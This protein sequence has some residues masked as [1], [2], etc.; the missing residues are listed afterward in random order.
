M[1]F[2]SVSG[3]NRTALSARGVFMKILAEYGVVRRGQDVFQAD[4]FMLRE[5]SEL[6]R[7]ITGLL[8][9]RGLEEVVQE[10]RLGPSTDLG[11]SKTIE[12]LLVLPRRDNEQCEIRFL[13]TPVD[14]N[15]QIT[16][17]QRKRNIFQLLCTALNN[18]FDVCVQELGE[19][20][21]GLERLVSNL[22]KS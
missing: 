16:R 12:V 5:L 13:V 6:I 17:E 4:R 7:E 15:P 18:A 3:V 1:F 11:K 21:G 14:L 8:G 2:H 10:I 19:R 20:P 22:R 9:G